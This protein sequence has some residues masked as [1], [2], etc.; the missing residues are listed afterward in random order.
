MMPWFMMRRTVRQSSVP[1]VKAR[2]TVEARTGTERRLSRRTVGHV[3]PVIERAYPLSASAAAVRHLE[4]GHVRGKLTISVQSAEP[5]HHAL[6][7]PTSA[8]TATT[9]EPGD[10]E[11]DPRTGIKAAAHGSAGADHR[12]VALR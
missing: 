4:T 3:T 12:E 1:G 7:S 9:D 10:L 11:P 2:L 5:A 6:R 8:E